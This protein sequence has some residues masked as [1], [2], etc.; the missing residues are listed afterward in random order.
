MYPNLLDRIKGLTID[1]IILIALIIITGDILNSFENTPE[2]MKAF[3]FVCYF[4]LYEP[5]LVSIK[6][7][8]IGQNYAGI[9][10]RKA[11]N[12]SQK[13]NFISALFRYGIKMVLGWVSFITF[14]TS[15]NK[16]ALHDLASGSIVIYK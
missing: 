16:R 10:V 1:A 14:F 6:G 9:K 7:A 4:I 13:I 8:T 3:L 2:I 12:E 15:N 5:V 11:N